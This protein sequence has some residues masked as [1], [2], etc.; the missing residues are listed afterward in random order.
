M[1][2]HSPIASLYRVLGAIGFEQPKIGEDRLPTIAWPDTRTGVCLPA[3][4]PPNDWE[5]V[6]LMGGEF[7]AVENFV[8]RLIDLRDNPEAAVR[9]NPPRID[10]PDLAKLDELSAK[11][12]YRLLRQ[13]GYP[14]PVVNAP[15]MPTISW[16]ELLRGIAFPPDTVPEGYFAIRLSPNEVTHISSVLTRLSLLYVGHRMRANGAS[17]TRRISS[18]EQELLSAMLQAGIPEPD[19]NLSVRDENGKFRG[20]ADFAWEQVDGVPVKVVLEVDGW[21]WHVGKDMAEELRTAASI[22]RSV[23]KSVQQQAKAKGAVDAAKRR[24]LQ[25]QGWSVMVVHDTEITK[26]TVG[27]IAADI[28][29]AIDARRPG[30]VPVGASAKADEF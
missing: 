18:D 7:R 24:V 12:L 27:A 10:E 13:C 9:M 14:R 15:G 26:Q 4:V 23:A 5:T 25:M 8:R 28:K 20:V 19:R 3:E 11:T 17:A 6:D 1:S 21:H 16:P 22:D 30:A 29:Q 2:E